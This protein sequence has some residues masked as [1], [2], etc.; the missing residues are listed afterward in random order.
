MYIKK[1]GQNTE[2]NLGIMQSAF[3]LKWLLMV[4]R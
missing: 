1:T 3:S 2:R 4:I